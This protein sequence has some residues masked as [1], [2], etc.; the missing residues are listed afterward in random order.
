MVEIYNYFYYQFYLFIYIDFEQW[1]P[2]APNKK[3]KCK[4]CNKPYI[5][6]GYPSEDSFSEPT[7][8]G[9]PILEVMDDLAQLFPSRLPPEREG[10]A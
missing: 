2:L 7:A 1:D 3:K 9:L 8:D 5:R 6:C 4:P 10:R